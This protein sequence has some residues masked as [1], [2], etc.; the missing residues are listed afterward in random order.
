[1]NSLVSPPITAN[2]CTSKALRPEDLARQLAFTRRE[3]LRAAAGLSLGSGLMASSLLS[4]TGN[5]PFQTSVSG[6]TWPQS[7]TCYWEFRAKL[8]KI[9]P[10]ERPSGCR[11]Q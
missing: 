7:N 8:N 9:R 6:R 1:M 10:Y 2:P 3:F 11:W 4:H 5:P